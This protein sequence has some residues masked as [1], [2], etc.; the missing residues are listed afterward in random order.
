MEN[1]E[2]KKIDYSIEERQAVANLLHDFYLFNE[3]RVND[4]LNTAQI[5]YNA[6]KK[7]AESAKKQIKEQLEQLI[8][9]LKKHGVVVMYTTDRIK[10]ENSTLEKIDR[11]IRSGHDCN[12]DNL[13]DIVGIRVVCLNLSSVDKLTHAIYNSGL[14][15]VKQ[16]KDYINFKDCRDGK[17]IYNGKEI[18]IEYCGPKSSGYRSKHILIEFPVKGI[19][20][21]G[22][23]QK[24]PIKAE[25]QLR[26]A[27]QDIYASEEHGINYKGKCDPEDKKMLKELGR[28][29]NFYDRIAIDEFKEVEVDDNSE[30]TDDELLC[31]D[32]FEEVESIYDSLNS[33]LNGKLSLLLRNNKDIIHKE[34][35]IKSIKSI[36]RKL[37]N[38][39][40]EINTEN[41][42]NEIKDI[43]GIRYICVNRQEAL[44]LAKLIK[45]SGE[46]EIIE[47][48]NY[49]SDPKESGYWGY[50]LKVVKHVKD[51]DK[52]R[53]I[54]SEIQIRTI[55]GDVWATLD[56]VYYNNNKTKEQE[57]NQLQ[58][59]I[60]L[61]EVELNLSRLKREKKMMKTI[62]IKE[63]IGKLLKKYESL[64]IEVSD[65]MLE[66]LINLEDRLISEEKAFSPAEI[67]NIIDNQINIFEN[68]DV[69]VSNEILDDLI[70]LEQRLKSI[71]GKKNYVLALKEHNKRKSM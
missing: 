63:Q 39:N 58:L 50:H 15:N 47:D 26:T 1:S 20:M 46:F 45:D 67:N 16:I 57:E 56:D 55:L 60:V 69:E 70:N 17:P 52:V 54:V 59:S 66:R 32:C 34:T 29:L 18:P 27:L 12:Y 65:E 43:I 68:S 23:A 30:L 25:I 14:F 5:K 19:G 62:A 71:N 28:K 4:I 40:L 8:S 21:D 3:N 24:I 53:D 38:K 2:I 37:K 51:G 22:T 36:C 33:E 9:S 6:N 48:H 41:I 42:L 11:K 64:G 44:E 13:Y 35:R 7:F 31:E 10:E 61:R 49:L